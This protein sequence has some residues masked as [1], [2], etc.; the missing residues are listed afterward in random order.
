[1]KYCKHLKYIKN[2]VLITDGRG[3]TD[4]SQRDDIADQINREHIKLSI[5]SPPHQTPTLTC[6]GIDF[7]DSTYGVKEEDKSPAKVPRHLG[8]DKANVMLG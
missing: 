7:D 3:A 8:N 2:V 5:L 1:M 4:W 6:R